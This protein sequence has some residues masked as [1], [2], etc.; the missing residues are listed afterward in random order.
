MQV[1][2]HQPSVRELLRGEAAVEGDH[3]RIEQALAGRLAEEEKARLARDRQSD[4]ERCD[5]TGS[6]GRR[7]DDESFHRRRRAGGGLETPPST[8]APDRDHFRL[9]ESRASR[10]SRLRERRDH[11]LGPVEIPVLAAVRSPGDA[12]RAEGRDERPDLVDRQH[13]GGDSGLS[14]HA[15]VLLE[16]RKRVLPVCEEQVSAGVE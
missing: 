10:P 5:Q 6:L 3:E 13:R 11:G 16:L 4:V 7:G 1:A 8:V 15:Y 14:L 12:L 9:L 2:R